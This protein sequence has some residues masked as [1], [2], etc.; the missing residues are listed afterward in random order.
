MDD[1]YNGAPE[2]AHSYQG[3]HLAATLAEVD[4]EAIQVMLVVVRGIFGDNLGGYVSRCFAANIGNNFSLADELMR[5]ILGI[6]MA[7]TKKCKYLWLESVT[8]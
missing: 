3:W 4:Q 7:A 5:A 6:E 2:K 8:L 1:G